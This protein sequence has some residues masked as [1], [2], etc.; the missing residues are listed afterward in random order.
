MSDLR[1][2]ISGASVAGPSLGYFLARSGAKVTIVERTSSLRTEGQN[3]DIRGVGIEVI[4]RMGVE[5]AIRAAT[6]G[7]IGMRF[8]DA[9]DKTQ[10]ELPAEPGNA[11]SPTSEIE[12]LRGQLARI[13][14]ENSKK[15]GV[16]YI[17]G[18]YISAI[19]QNDDKVFVSFANS[20]DTYEYDLVVAAD[21]QNSKTRSLTF[22]EKANDCIDSLGQY[23]IFFSMS[24][25]DSDSDWARW[26]NAPDRRC[27]LIRPDNTGRTRVV[28][29]MINSDPKMEDALAGSVDEQKAV[30]HDLFADAGWES[31]RT[32]EG[33]TTA[34]DCYMLRVAQ[35]KLPVWTNGRVA[36]IGDAGYCPSPISGMGTTCALVGSYILAGEIAKHGRD[37]KTAF[38]EY[39]KNLRPIVEKAQKLAPGGPKL[40]NPETKL[41]IKVLNS[42]LGFMTATGLNKLLEKLASGAA[43]GI[44]LPEYKF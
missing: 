36:L 9:E 4:R 31:R 5:D 18:D 7:E 6:T 28:L 37:Y 43:D 12:I 1:I 19:D 8:V 25:S 16:E 35:V 3:I 30:W 40:L 41:G 32:L 34:E 29:A 39:E 26:Y 20:K 2:L 38:Q 21:G 42:T 27:I 17:F 22:G 10:A 14:Y 15:E 11:A 44:A 33:L 24:R 23:M 13:L